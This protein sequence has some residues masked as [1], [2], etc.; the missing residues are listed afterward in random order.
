MS[1]LFK[2]KQRAIQDIYKEKGIE[3]RLQP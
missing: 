3:S 1:A 2:G